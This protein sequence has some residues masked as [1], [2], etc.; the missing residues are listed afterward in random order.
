[1]NHLVA[2]CPS[3]LVIVIDLPSW[4]LVVIPLFHLSSPVPLC[5]LWKSLKP[6]PAYGDH[7][8]V[9]IGG[10]N[11]QD[12]PKSRPKVLLPVSD[13]PISATPPQTRLVCKVTI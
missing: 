9:S 6:S 1:M 12:K 4:S 11:K 3:Q 7:I 8:M 13:H 2:A 5:L 10:E